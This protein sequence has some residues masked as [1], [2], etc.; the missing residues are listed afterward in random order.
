MT[1]ADETSF[2]GVFSISAGRSSGASDDIVGR[3]DIESQCGYILTAA[4][5]SAAVEFFKHFV[6]TVGNQSLI[7]ID[8]DQFP[9]RRTLTAFPRAASPARSEAACFTGEGSGRSE[10]MPGQIG[11]RCGH[12]KIE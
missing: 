11:S 2:V 9:G 3:K 4:V 1:N 7:E 8:Q 5:A 12:Q 6:Q 10:A